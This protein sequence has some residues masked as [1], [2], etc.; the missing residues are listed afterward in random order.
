MSLATT[1]AR[2]VGA[3]EWRPSM[4][5]ILHGAHLWQSTE[6]LSSTCARLV[7]AAGRD[8]RCL[9]RVVVR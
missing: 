9:G 6:P 8:S 5:S 7:G 3:I 4:P 2:L 1:V